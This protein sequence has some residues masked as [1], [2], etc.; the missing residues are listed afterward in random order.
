M[1][2]RPIYQEIL[3]AVELLIYWLSSQYFDW[4]TS[5]PSSALTALLTCGAAA[6]GLLSVYDGPDD[7]GQD[8]SQ[9][10]QPHKHP[11][12]VLKTERLYH[13]RFGRGG[14]DRASQ[15][16]RNNTGRL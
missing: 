4:T 5:F 11:Q 3:G 7:H 13:H 1:S 9:S 15:L 2:A 10:Q 14:G 16:D 12:T 6:S 8:G